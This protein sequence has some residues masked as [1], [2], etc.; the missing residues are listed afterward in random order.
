MSIKSAAIIILLMFSVN[1]FAQ[2]SLSSGWAA[3]ASSKYRISNQ[4]YV[5]ENGITVPLDIYYRRDVDT[6][7]PTLMFIHGGWWVGGS[8]NTQMMALLPWLEMGWNVVNID[9]R[10][11]G[12]ALAPAALVDSFCALRYISA[13]AERFNIDT[14]RIVASGQSA[15][16]HLALSVAMMTDASFDSTCPEGETAKIAAVVNWY[17]ATDV[18]DSIEGE[19]RSESGAR[20]FG[21]MQRDDALAL[22]ERLSPLNYVRDDLPAI[23]T[24]QGDADTTVPYAQG[25]ALHQALSDTNVKNQLLTIPGAGHGGFS[26][27][28]HRRIYATIQNFLDETGLSH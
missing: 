5:T 20:W 18:P 9:Y 17:G 12:E 24:I 15:G 4:S 21:N 16:G 7:Q 8:K 14:N 13:N 23:L 27:A 2:S 11:G 1:S 26:T 19:N 3:E 10:L 28:E 6:P 25:V 22:A